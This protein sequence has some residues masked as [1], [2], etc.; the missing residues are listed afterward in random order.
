LS[1]PFQSVF[2]EGSFRDHPAVVSVSKA[3]QNR[4]GPAF[5]VYADSVIVQ[6]IYR[7]PRRLRFRGNLI[8]QVPFSYLSAEITSIMEFDTLP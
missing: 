2:V 4:V 1:D 3:P 5:Q 7:V 8:I 6:R